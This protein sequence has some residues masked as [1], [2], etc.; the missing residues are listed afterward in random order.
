MIGQNFVSILTQ[1]I[2][3][4]NSAWAQLKTIKL[5]VS[6]NVDCCDVG[7]NSQHVIHK[8]KLKVI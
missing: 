8:E 7:L 4:G 5:I 3:D 2:S 6:R 1:L